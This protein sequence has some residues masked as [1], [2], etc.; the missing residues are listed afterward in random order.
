MDNSGGDAV[1]DNADFALFDF[2]ERS[3]PDL[4]TNPNIYGKNPTLSSPYGPASSTGKLACNSTYGIHYESA[5]HLDL[6]GASA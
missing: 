2:V 5:F 6:R 4:L 3:G 1:N